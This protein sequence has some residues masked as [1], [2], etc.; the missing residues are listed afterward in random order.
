[1]S[2]PPPIKVFNFDLR[3]KIVKERKFP[4]KEI[5][6]KEVRLPFLEENNPAPWATAIWEKEFYGEFKQDVANCY[7]KTIVYDT[8]T[9]IEELCRQYVFEEVQ[10]SSSKGREKMAPSEYLMR[11]VLM[12]NLFTHPRDVGMNVVAL[13]YVR[14]EWKKFPGKDRAE[15]TG[16]IIMDGWARTDSQVDI[17]LE[18]E[19]IFVGD[20]RVMRTTVKANAFEPDLDGKYFDNTDYQELMALLGV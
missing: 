1:M 11:N 14:E 13:Q 6:I 17:I 5:D 10:R 15:P 8:T 4:D 3:A 16:Q 9:A 7:Y 20:K 18:M 2:F 12:S 19:A